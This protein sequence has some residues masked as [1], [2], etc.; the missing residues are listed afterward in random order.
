MWLAADGTVWLGSLGEA[1]LMIHDTQRRQ[2]SFVAVPRGAE[3]RMRADRDGRRPCRRIEGP[4]AV[5]GRDD[6]AA[7]MPMAVAV[8]LGVLA[9]AR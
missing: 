6:A 9:Q 4:A 1:R 2:E 7:G 3:I 5:V 8:A